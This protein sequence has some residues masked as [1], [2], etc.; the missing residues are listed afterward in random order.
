MKVNHFTGQ[1]N[2]FLTAYQQSDLIGKSIFISLLISS[3]CCW[4]ILIYKIWLTFSASRNSARFYQEFKKQ[5][6]NIL[7]VQPLRSLAGH[8]NPFFAI[9]SVLRS[10]AVDILNKNRA[11]VGDDP[12][13]FT[14]LSSSDMGLIEVNLSSCITCQAKH[15]EKNLFILST[16]VG[17]APLLGLLGTVWGILITFSEM[18]GTGFGHS[19]ATMLSGLSLALTT[20]VLGLMSAIPALI[21]YNYLKNSVLE[22]TADMKQFAT[23]SLA[24][25]ERQ[26]RKVEL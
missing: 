20:T 23:E 10:H 19:Q 14:Y 12:D 7:N 13:G 26:Y 3:I 1:E 21:A 5:K 25:L 17:L 4:V 16:I 2:I 18:T 24:Y 6:A 9:Y 8:I 15:L 11:V 22:F